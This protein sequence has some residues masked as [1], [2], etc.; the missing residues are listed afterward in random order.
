MSCCSR[1]FDLWMIWF[2]ANGAA[3]HSGFAASCALSSVVMRS[4]HSSSCSFGRAFSAGKAPTT[5]DTHCAMTRS[6]LEMMKSGAPITGSR[7]C[8]RISGFDMALPLGRLAP[9]RT[10][11]NRARLGNQG[12]LFV[13]HVGFDKD[14]RAAFLDDASLGQ[15]RAAPGRDEL[16]LHVEGH[17]RA[18]VASR[19]RRGPDRDVEKRHGD[20]AMR[21][22]ELVHVMVFELHPQ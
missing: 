5:P 10:L 17:Y 1:S 6:G 12:A 22:A 15:Q 11:Q 20:P 3:L 4:S 21:D 8:F 7:R 19:P 18:L 13:M 9:A 14:K 2:T 16:R